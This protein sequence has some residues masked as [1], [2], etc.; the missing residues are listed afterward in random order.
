MKGKLL[1]LF[2]LI[3][4]CFISYKAV[5]SENFSHGSSRNQ[6]NNTIAK[7]ASNVHA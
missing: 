1:A 3:V 2:L 7:S 6:V 4:T 5:T